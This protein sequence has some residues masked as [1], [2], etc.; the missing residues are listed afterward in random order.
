MKF[1]VRDKSKN[2]ILSKLKTLLFHR[3]KRNLTHI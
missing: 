3:T 1:I 2:K